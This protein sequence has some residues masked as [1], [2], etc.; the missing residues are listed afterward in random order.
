MIETFHY[1]RYSDV[2]ALARMKEKASQTVSVVIPALNEASTVGTIV[3]AIK[4]CCIEEVSLIDE[5]L[6]IDGGSSDATVA[7]AAESGATVYAINEIGPTVQC[8]GKGVALWKSQFIANGDI[9]IF[10]DSDLVEFDHRFVY[11]LLGVMLEF[12]GKL[13]VKSFYNRPLMIGSHLFAQQGGRVTE[14]LV[15][16]LIELFVPELAEISQ[17][18][19]GEYALRRDVFR[20]F[21]FWSGYA[22]EIGLLLDTYFSYGNSVI[23]QV[24]LEHRAHRNRSIQELRAM[25]SS[26][27]RV[28]LQKMHIHGEVV[29]ANECYERF[30]KKDDI[31]NNNAQHDI[32]LEPYI[33]QIGL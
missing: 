4:R 12:P 30:F 5:I 25:A 1:S 10:I 22:V 27:L 16:P 17:P 11:G 2:L 26:I 28:F 23:A 6:V 14:L 32:E 8:K 29:L 24:D 3:T 21:P 15:K 31:I 7:I 20:T 13:M 18:L 9:L 33:K 19:S